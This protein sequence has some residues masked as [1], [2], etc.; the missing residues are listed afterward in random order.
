[1]CVFYSCVDMNRRRR[2]HV[3]DERT[4]ILRD[5]DYR[6]PPMTDAD[7]TYRP[8]ALVCSLLL[9]FPSALPSSRS[10]A[11]PV[12]V[13]LTSTAV[14]S[15]VSP[16]RVEDQAEWQICTA[17]CGDFETTA[18][19]GTATQ[20]RSTAAQASSLILGNYWIMTLRIPKLPNPPCQ[21]IAGPNVGLAKRWSIQVW[22]A[23]KRDV[24]IGDRISWDSLYAHNTRLNAESGTS[25]HAELFHC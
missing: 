6:I 19:D 5:Q 25:P 12:A 15:T 21:F 11:S 1:M 3:T 10:P 24:N 16:G 22:R 20:R 13:C 7:P 8:P 18:K 2:A 14:R 17:D 9:A 23:G 4:E